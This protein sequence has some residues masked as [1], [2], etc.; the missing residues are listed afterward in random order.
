MVY[1]VTEVVHAAARRLNA[2]LG[3]SEIYRGPMWDEVE[4]VALA[5]YLT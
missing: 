3:Y 4:R 1:T 2:R 5:K